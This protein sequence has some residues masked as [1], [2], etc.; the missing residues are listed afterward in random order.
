MEQRQHCAQHSA[1]ITCRR[2][3]KA[4]LTTR[5]VSP[6]GRFLILALSLSLC[7]AEVSP[8]ETLCGGELVDTLQF[9][10][11]ERGFYFS[12]P[13][14]RT[15][16]RYGGGI[17]EE[18]CFRSCALELLELYCAKPTVTE[19]D[20]SQHIM[21][22]L[23]TETVQRPYPVRFSLWQR[24]SVQRLRRGLPARNRAL[25]R[26][27]LAGG[28]RAAEGHLHQALAGSLLEG[29]PLTDIRHSAT[30]VPL[31]H[32]PS[33]HTLGTNEEAG[34]MSL[35]G[36]RPRVHGHRDARVRRRLAQL[37]HTHTARK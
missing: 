33:L 27:L 29:G 26:P 10:C 16:G 34:V 11:G 13:H 22:A 5:G 25:R 17:V 19:R 32:R 21:P 30:P 1:R 12:R 18:C 28:K 7:I 8:L 14:Q 24:Q 6:P 3:R 36:Y 9:V 23:H 2:E 31:L 35:L 15:R 20:L 37:F 4:N